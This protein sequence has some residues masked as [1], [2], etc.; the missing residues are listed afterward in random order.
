MNSTQVFKYSL[1]RYN[2]KQ[3]IHEISLYYRYNEIWI[4]KKSIELSFKYLIKKIEIL[5]LQAK[6]Y[7]INSNTHSSDT[8]QN[9]I[10]KS[11]KRR[12][13]YLYF[14]Y[15]S[16]LKVKYCWIKGSFWEIIPHATFDTGIEWC[17]WNISG[18]VG[19]VSVGRI[20]KDTP[21][22]TTPSHASKS[23]AMD[24]SSHIF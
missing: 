19:L 12:M 21:P 3:D 10:F 2:S 16:R 17:I 23:S 5:T 18:N 9:Q 13:R 20:N 6:N 4:N 8:I 14:R 22:L 7:K 1:F 15:N 11:H 24:I